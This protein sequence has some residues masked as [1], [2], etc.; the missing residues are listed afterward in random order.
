MDKAFI[1][2]SCFP[3]WPET[4][5]FQLGNVEY[6]DVASLKI[7]L[8]HV[9]AIYDA[10]IVACLNCLISVVFQICRMCNPDDL[11]P[12]NDIDLLMNSKSSEDLA[13]T[14]LSMLKASSCEAFHTATQVK[15][16]RD[17]PQDMHTIKDIASDVENVD[18]MNNGHVKSSDET[19]GEIGIEIDNVIGMLTDNCND[20][21]VKA[22]DSASKK[23]LGIN[24]MSAEVEAVYVVPNAKSKKSGIDVSWWTPRGFTWYLT[25]VS[26]N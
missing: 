4:S 15:V 23:V 20:I 26:V 2:I 10:S 1:S 14:I 12:N 13:S 16:N 19:H 3:F 17:E 24:D 7:D 9:S 8:L 11:D 6:C 18:F 5:P 21:V 22:F 25:Y